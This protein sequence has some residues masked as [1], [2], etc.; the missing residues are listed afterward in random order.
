MQDEL[1]EFERNNV[2]RLVPTPRNASVIG[3]KWVFRNKMVKEGNVIRNKAPMFVKCY[4]QEEGI[5]YE[6]TFALVAR[7][8]SIWIFLAY[9]THKNF[10]V[11]QMDVKCEFL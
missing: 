2:R 7:L 11:Y 9:T 3:L 8:E 1:N 4:F 5:D 10:E 6:E